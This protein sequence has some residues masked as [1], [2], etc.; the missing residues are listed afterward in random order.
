[1]VYSSVYTLTRGIHSRAIHRW[2]AGMVARDEHHG[3]TALPSF[4]LSWYAV[5]FSMPWCAPDNARSKS[6]ALSFPGVLV[7]LRRIRHLATRSVR[8]GSGGRAGQGGAT[9]LFCE[10]VEVS[11]YVRGESCCLT[12]AFRDRATSE[13]ILHHHRV[14]QARW[15]DLIPTGIFLGRVRPHLFPFLEGHFDREN[16]HLLQLVI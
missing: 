9:D 10:V 14:C 12:R 1:M 16:N 2:S 11:W 6:I 13:F 3:L 7:L 5:G 8:I 15:R 4:A